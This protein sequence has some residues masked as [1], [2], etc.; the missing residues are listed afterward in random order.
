MDVLA[1]EAAAAR[2]GR[3]R[4]ADARPFLLELHT[5]RFRA[6]SMYDPELYRAKDEVEAWKEREP[7]HSFA[8]R[9][10]AAGMLTEDE[11][12]ALDGAAVRRESTRRSRSPKQGRGSR[13]RTCCA[14]SPRRAQPEGARP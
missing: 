13:S 5:Y 6:H 3:S 9:L 10:K 2:R 14:T 4:A 8:Q 7:I 11:F 12:L 1:V